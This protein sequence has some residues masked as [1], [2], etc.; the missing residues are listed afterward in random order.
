VPQAKE[1]WKQKGK[2]PEETIEAVSWSA[3]GEAL[4]GM[5][6][7]GHH[8][9]TKQTVGICGVGKWVKR[10]GKWEVD[11]CPRC[12]CPEPAKH[13]TL[14]R[15]QGADDTWSRAIDNLKRWLED[16]QTDPFITKAIITGL[17]TWRVSDIPQ[18]PA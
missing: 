11:K 10:W 7:A 14:C 4:K 5:P 12:G 6:R 2:A 8:F 9:I 3:I 1:Y 18:D 16:N 13:V 17:N 15:G